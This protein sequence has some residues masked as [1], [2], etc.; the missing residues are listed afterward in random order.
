MSSTYSIQVPA[1]S[2][3]LGA[4]FDSLGLAVGL[5]LKVQVQESCRGSSEINMEGEGAGELVNIRENLMWKVIL[6]VFQGEGRSLPCLRLEVKNQIPLARGLGSSAAAIVAALGIYEA[7]VGQE[8]SQENFFRYALEFEKHPDNLTAAR[9]GGFTVSCVDEQ[10]R[11]SFFR[12]KVQKELKVL[13]VVPDIQLPTSEARTV[14]PD[15]LKMSDVVFNLQRSALTVAA[16]IGGQYQF[17]RESL[18]DKLHQPYRASLIPGLQEIL[19]LNGREIPNLLGLSLSGAGPSV[20][21]FIQGDG[22]DV[23]E[24]VQSIFSR[25]GVTCSPLELKIDNQGRSICGS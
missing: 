2:A 11:V 15:Q 3:N 21:A 17:L 14:V 6:R 5:Y 16:L 23:F 20:V 8:L 13:L 9:F 10:G 7:W 1:S 24:Q 4:G 19:E 25:Q 12:T 22:Q 18:R